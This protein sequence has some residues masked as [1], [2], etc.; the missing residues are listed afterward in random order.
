MESISDPSGERFVKFKTGL[1]I[2]ALEIWTIVPLLIYYQ[3]YID[4]NAN[5]GGS[6]IKWII[7]VIVLVITDYIVFHYKDQW[8]IYKKEFEE[9]PTRKNK[10]GGWIVFGVVLFIII[11]LVF[12]FFC[13]DLNARKN[14]TGPYAPEI[15]AKERREDSL[16]KAQQVENL[17]KIYGEGDKK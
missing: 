10:V 16:Q 13:L 8:Y 4:P 1:A 7:G 3:L 14:Q 5:I 12:S 9:L 2:I 17:K 11:N 6:N 15:V